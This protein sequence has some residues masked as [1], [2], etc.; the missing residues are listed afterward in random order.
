MPIALPMW[1]AV[2]ADGD[3]RQLN[4]VLRGTAR[5]TLV[6]A[7]LFAAGLAAGGS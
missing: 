5:L 4:A 6:F 2:R 3:P 1:R 7:L